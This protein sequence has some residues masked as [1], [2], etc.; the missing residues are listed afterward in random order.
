MKVIFYKR[1][2]ERVSRKEVRKNRLAYAQAKRTG[3]LGELTVSIQ[4]TVADSIE[5]MRDEDF[6]DWS[7][8]YT[9]KR[10]PTR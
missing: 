4:P 10:I 3:K 6:A 1:S 8:S 2:G 9:F 5:I 7:G